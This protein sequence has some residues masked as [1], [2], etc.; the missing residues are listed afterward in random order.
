MAGVKVSYQPNEFGIGIAAESIT[1]TVVA[2]TTQLFSES[3]SLPS[4][5]PIQ[6]L[7]PKAGEF[8]AR[9]ETIY[10]TN[11]GTPSEVTVSGLLNDT[12][13]SLLEGIFHTAAASN[14]ITVTDTYTAPA[15]PVGEANTAAT[16]TYTVKILHPQATDDNGNSPADNSVVLRGCSVTAFSVS[17]DASGDGRLT[18]SAT[19]KTGFLP[20]FEQPAGT[21]TP[22]VETGMR[23]IH[24]LSYRT[25]AGVADPVMQSFNLSIENPA[26]YIGFD[27]VNNVP[28]SISRS[29]P[30]GPVVNLS[31]VIKLDKDTKG[32]LAN[33]MNASAQTGLKNHLSNESN[34]AAALTGA[35]EF[36]FNCDKAIITGMSFNEQAAMMYSVEQK[37]LFGSFTIRNS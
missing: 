11:K 12:A 1:G 9:D 4:F 3:V 31:S 37:L 2:N 27:P 30:E 8:V 10:S 15:L 5:S 35:T 34:Q 18:Y 25:I 22:P 13:L 6:D 20:L 21:T 23:N 33:F 26:E 19:F 16:K 17:G 24:D 14:V 28:Y 36:A 7:A 32:L 29:V